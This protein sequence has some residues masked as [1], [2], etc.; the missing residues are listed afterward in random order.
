MKANHLRNKGLLFS[1]LRQ[2]T[3]IILLSFALGLL[4]NQVRSNSLPLIADWAPEVRLASDSGESLIISL[5]EAKALCSDKG[6]VF[7]DA[8]SP[9]D[10][11]QGHIRCAQNIPWQSFDAYIDRVFNMIPDDAWIVTYC[12]GE[13]CS[14]SED[15]AKEL[16]SMGYQKVKVLLNGWTRWLEAGLPVKIG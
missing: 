4:M 3:V 6:A 7:L 5:E 15:L 9:E 2:V 1:V 11:A 14:L 8:R 12:D 16:V 10:Y 13:H